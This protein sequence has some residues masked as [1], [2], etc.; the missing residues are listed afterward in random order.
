MFISIPK[1]FFV[2]V[3]FG[4]T[5][6]LN[7]ENNNLELDLNM[8]RESTGKK[9]ND[10][11]EMNKEYLK[12]SKAI[13]EKQDIIDVEVNMNEEQCGNKEITKTE[14]KEE[15]TTMYMPLKGEIDLNKMC[16]EV[17]KIFELIDDEFIENIEI[18]GCNEKK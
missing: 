16:N 3:I 9:N 14:T 1:E 10:N 13:K 4:D 5:F 15:G 7:E 8:Y 11:L 12:N 2:P 17:G 6:I 18:K